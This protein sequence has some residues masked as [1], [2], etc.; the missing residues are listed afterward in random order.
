MYKRIFAFLVITSGFISLKAQVT[1]SLQEPPAGVVQK[2]QL[3]NLTLVN[4]ANT[5]MTV[6]IGLS[7]FDV[8]SN[9]TVMT[10]ITR[11]ITLTKGVKQIK[12]MDVAP[13]DYNYYSTLFDMARVPEGFIPVGVY[14]AC[15]TVYTDL[16]TS[17]GIL[18]EDCITI[19]VQPLSP[20]QL[21]MPAD[22]AALTS[23]YPQFS[24]IPPAPVVLFSDLNYDMVVTEVMQDQTAAAAI[25][26]NIPVYQ[27]QRYGSL[28]NNYPSSY[29]GLDTGKVYAWK[30]Y[31]KNGETVAAQSEV[32]TFKIVQ[33]KEEP[34]VP[35]NSMYVELTTGS[36]YNSSA[37]IPDRVLGIKYYS[38]D[39][40]HKSVIRF[41]DSHGRVVQEQTKQIEYGNNF[42]VFK[43]NSSFSEETIY[44]VEITDLQSAV[45]SATF[46]IRN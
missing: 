34:L 16:K 31:A 5:T 19:D 35:A 18:A 20:P 30:V 11:P 42:L 15:Y 8:K 6:T 14:R 32:W 25:E 38:Y 26:E 10:G 44:T 27:L 9:Q 1:V 36:N 28:V 12:A 13:V 24:W 22:S 37:T 45:Y 7:L 40:A 3:W 29:K 17:E 33:Q 46:M 21:T 43:L 23:K 41:K 39:K 2:S 4:S